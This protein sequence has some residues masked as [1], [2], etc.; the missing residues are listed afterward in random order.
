MHIANKK[1]SQNKKN[2]HTKR[3]RLFMREHVLP[4]W[5]GVKMTH[6][7]FFAV[8]KPSYN[9]QIYKFQNKAKKKSSNLIFRFEV[10]REI[11]RA[12]I[13]RRKVP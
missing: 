8:C 4:N 2:I 6:C 13:T 9:T 11:F 10:N 3:F 1:L 7:T 5:E 12:N